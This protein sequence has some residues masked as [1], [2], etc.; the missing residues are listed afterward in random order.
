MFL[1]FFLFALDGRKQDD[2]SSEAD[3]QFSHNALCLICC[4]VSWTD[5]SLQRTKRRTR[6]NMSQQSRG[7]WRNS[8]L[9]EDILLEEARGRSL[10]LTWQRHASKSLSERGFIQNLELVLRRLGVCLCARSFTGARRVQP[11]YSAL[12]NLKVTL[13]W[14][15]LFD[16][17][18]K[19]IAHK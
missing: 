4:A 12:F 13:F 8:S 10:I 7:T 9:S 6:V 2:K 11:A 16:I 14:T 1:M 18:I 17:G 15:F 5:V 19:K 3:G